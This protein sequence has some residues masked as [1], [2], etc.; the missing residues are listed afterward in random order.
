MVAVET[1]Q[2]CVNY[3]AA[4]VW[5]LELYLANKSDFHSCLACSRKINK[6][7]GGSD[8]LAKPPTP[9]DMSCEIYWLIVNSR[10]KGKPTFGH[11]MA[12]FAGFFGWVASNQKRGFP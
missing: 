5:Y 2:I 12:S 10:E 3:V 8:T 1:N 11:F 7:T 9:V 6:S 4:E